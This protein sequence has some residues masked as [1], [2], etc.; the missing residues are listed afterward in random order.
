MIAEKTRRFIEGLEYVFVASADAAGT[1]HLAAGREIEVL[2]SGH[3]AFR[4]WFCHT[5]LANIGEN[6]RISVTFV[7]PATGAGY[8]M[9]GV[10]ESRHETAI[11]DGLA[12][13][14]EEP[15]TPQV[16]SQ[17]VVRIEEVLEFSSGPHSDRPL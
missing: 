10:V 8:Q 14:R 5:T 7:E 2:D 6:P 15:G 12:P 16:Q 4:N 11:L 3:V 17:F 9:L 13:G 1:P